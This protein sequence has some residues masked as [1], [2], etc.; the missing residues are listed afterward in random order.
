MVFIL[1][2]LDLCAFCTRYSGRR[3]DDSFRRATFIRQR[4]RFGV[5]LFLL[6]TPFLLDWL[7]KRLKRSRF[8]LGGEYVV[9]GVHSRRVRAA[10]V[11]YLSSTTETLTRIDLSI[12]ENLFAHG[13]ELR[14][15]T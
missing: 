4:F 14:R 5:T 9:D 10:T 12:I 2:F 15:Y 3:V 8:T 7:R 13:C 6:I 1:G 11:S